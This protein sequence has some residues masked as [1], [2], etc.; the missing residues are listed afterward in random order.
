MDRAGYYATDHRYKL[1]IC[2][3]PLLKVYVKTNIIG[4]LFW[5][6]VPPYVKNLIFEEINRFSQ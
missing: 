4:T 5:R 3:V 2:H 6:G 1:Y